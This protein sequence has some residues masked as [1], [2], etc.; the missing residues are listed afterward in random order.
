MDV[1]KRGPITPRERVKGALRHQESDRV[2]FDF[3]AVPEVCAALRQ[4]LGVETDEE[5]LCLLGVD[6]RLV[7]PDYVGPAPRVQ[8]DGTYFDA[9]GTHR[10]KVSN[11]FGSIYDEYASFPLAGAQTAAEVETWDG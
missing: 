1:R 10:R 6:C 3:W 5:V 11:S 4:R 2:P 7:A 8:P 9:W